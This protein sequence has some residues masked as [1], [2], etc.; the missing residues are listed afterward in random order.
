MLL[1]T[2]GDLPRLRNKIATEL[3]IK[4]ND[5]ELLRAQE[6]ITSLDALPTAT[7]VTP[8]RAQH[9]YLTKGAAVAVATIV[10]LLS[11]QIVRLVHT[12]LS[13]TT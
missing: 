8:A 1:A 10:L 11:G 6:Y 3:K 7:T 5:P 13:G 9:S 4:P 12:S 2:D